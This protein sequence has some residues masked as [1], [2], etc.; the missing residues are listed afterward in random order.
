M[1]EN[2]T[3]IDRISDEIEQLE[4]NSNRSEKETRNEFNK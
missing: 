4:R 2:N 3:K 1:R